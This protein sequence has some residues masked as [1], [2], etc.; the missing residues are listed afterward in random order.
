MLRTWFGLSIEAEGAAAYQTVGRTG[1]YAPLR[2]FVLVLRT[3]LARSELYARERNGH[4]T[5]QK[6]RFTTAGFTSLVE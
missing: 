1:E 6:N 3:L 2:G 5:H 4:L